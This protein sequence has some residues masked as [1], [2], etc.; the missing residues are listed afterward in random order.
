MKEVNVSQSADANP[1]LGGGKGIPDIERKG[2]KGSKRKLPETSN[3]KDKI[4]TFL[5]NMDE[6][7]EQYQ[8]ALQDMHNGKMKRL[9]R[10]LDILAGENK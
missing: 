3:T 2:K 6:R 1:P 8:K 7:S 10:F 4:V 5:G 9:D